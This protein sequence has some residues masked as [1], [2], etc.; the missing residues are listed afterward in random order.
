MLCIHP[1]T[2]YI[3]QGPQK[4]RK[5]KSNS[6]ERKYSVNIFYL[7]GKIAV[8][9][10]AYIHNSKYLD[11]IFYITGKKHMFFSVG[12]PQPGFFSK[13]LCIAIWYM[14]SKC[15]LDMYFVVILN[16]YIYISL[17]ISFYIYIYIHVMY[18]P[19]Y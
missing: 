16:I 14:W 5:T 11:I 9:F 15:H 17:S 13:K 6:L 1:S 18:T 19:F 2:E 10:S 4:I 3:Q 12:M 7:I 8:L